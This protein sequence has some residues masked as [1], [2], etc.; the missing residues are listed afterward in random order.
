MR[1]RSVLS[2]VL[3][4]IL[5]LSLLMTGC[6][7]QSSGDTEKEKP[8]PEDKNVTESSSDQKEDADVDSD[9]DADGGMDELDAFFNMS[10]YSA[11][12]FT[13]IIPDEIK[14]NTNV[15]LNYT[16]ATDDGQLGVMIASGE[17]PDII[18]TDSYQ[19]RLSNSDLCYSYTELVDKFGASFDD[20]SSEEIS[21]AKSMSTDGDYYTVLNN[22]N[23]K[24][25]WAEMKLGAPGQA[26]IFYRKDLME[27]LGNPTIENLEDF[28]NVLEQCKTVYPDKVPLGLGGYWK[29][30]AISSWI[31]VDQNRYDGTNYY[32]PASAPKYKD[33]LQTANDYARKGYITP[34]AYANENEGD[35]HQV[36]YSGE[37]VFY[38]WFLTYSNFAQLQAET[39][40]IDPNAEWALLPSIGEATV[41]EDKGWAGVFVSK[42]CKD[43]EAAARL[44]TYMFSADGEKTSMWGRE[45]I[46]YT[47]TEDNVPEFSDEYITSR[48]D[49]TLTEKYQPFFFT[50]SAI[51]EIYSNYAGIDQ[52][53]LDQVNSYVQGYKSYP[54]IG[55]AKPVA[56]SDEGIILA[57]LNEIK[58]NYEAKVIF[59]TSDDEFE[60]YY[61]EY[62]DALK[63]SGIDEYN[64]YMSKRIQEVRADYGF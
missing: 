23:T 20:V 27:G 61:Q 41:S 12:A 15:N 14:K 19:D 44:L 26:A 3:S 46:D 32:Y 22:Y 42:N 59:A 30:Q 38:P 13:G 29:L 8:T 28:E 7:K 24:E 48:G 53:F 64:A 45:G 54:E 51:T 57:K 36:A 60:K 35:S 1:K 49:G 18:I 50:V 52:S 16:I 37:C 5:V 10:W 34:E 62:M 9:A 56:S 2:S 6:G 55:I 47:L 63:S 58:K 21:I 4:I 31:G 17:L 33:F 25:E 43:P 11:N 40:K 39:K